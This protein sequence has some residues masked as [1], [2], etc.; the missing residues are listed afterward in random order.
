MKNEDVCYTREVAI[1][2][3]ITMERES[4]HTYR[5]AYLRI[6]EPRIKKLVKKLALDELEHKTILE[7]AYFEETISLHDDGL[8][9][10]PSMNL[11]LILA[12][13]PLD[14]DA[15]DQDVMVHA[16]HDKKRIVDFY[17]KM[18]S[19]CAGA[20]MESMFKKLSLEELNHLS[21]LEEMY[22][23]LYMQHN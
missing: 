3:A 17:K 8:S 23:G 19:Q 2:K 4:F 22:E 5:D 21:Q 20:P 1:E 16:I 7:K 10:G 12:E 15:D 9:E 6:R 11:S 13:K 14:D 18:T